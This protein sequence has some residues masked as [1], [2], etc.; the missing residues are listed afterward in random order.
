MC[1][2]QTCAFLICFRSIWRVKSVWSVS[3]VRSVHGVRC[4]RRVRGV[5]GVRGVWGVRGVECR[6]GIGRSCR[7]T[8]VDSRTITLSYQGRPNIE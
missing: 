7:G 4:V 6:W 5:Q 3:G 8:A 2:V 1:G